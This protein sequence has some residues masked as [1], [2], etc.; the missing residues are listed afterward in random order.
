VIDAVIGL[1]FGI[2]GTILVVGHAG[3]YKGGKDK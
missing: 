3:N 2:Q 1:G